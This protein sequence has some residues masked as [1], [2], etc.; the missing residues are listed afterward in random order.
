M[1]A[2]PP[3]AEWYDVSED[4]AAYW[5]LLCRLWEDGESF[6]VVEHDVAFRP[7]VVEQFTVCSEPWCLFPYANICHW[8]CMEAWA[9]ML[10]CTRFS[11]ELIR[12]CPDA[13]ASIPP[14]LR[15]WHNVCDSIAG[16]KVG[17]QPAPLR[18]KSLRAAGFTHHWHHPGVDH[19]TWR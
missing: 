4:S 15:D 10:G 6:M 12:A 1:A 2:A 7:D 19:I 14:D 3:N 13:V 9:N 18:P 5:R 16:D 17:G 11:S 8:E